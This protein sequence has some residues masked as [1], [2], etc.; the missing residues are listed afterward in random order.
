MVAKGS[1]TKNKAKAKKQGTRNRFWLCGAY[2]WKDLLFSGSEG[3]YKNFLF[4]F[5]E[6]S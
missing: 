6:S 3:K 5:I 2:N 1:P 4:F